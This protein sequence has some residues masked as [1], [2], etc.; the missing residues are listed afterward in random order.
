MDD[1]I[2][3]SQTDAAA[4]LGVSERTLAYMRAGGRGPAWVRLSPRRLGY[5]RA[6]LE[7]WAEEQS[8][9]AAGPVPIAA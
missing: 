3:L 9:Q 4:A 5:S 1:R 7:R 6:A 2:F 8:R